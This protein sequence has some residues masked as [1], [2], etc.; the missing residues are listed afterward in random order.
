MVTLDDYKAARDVIGAGYRLQLALTDLADLAIQVQHVRWNLGPGPEGQAELDDFEALCR[1]ASDAIA[2]RMRRLGVPADG[3][4][5]TVHLDLLY[6]PLPL[7]Q[8]DIDGARAV[9]THRV[10]QM[11][12]RIRESIA[13]LELG[14]PD[15][16]DLLRTIS[17]EI[18]AWPVADDEPS[19]A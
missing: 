6:D 19:R 9:L 18:A 3:R 7:G 10:A 5:S 4:V 1:A 11:G 13:L 8:F 17:K 16:A 12:A 2:G 14:D 15:S